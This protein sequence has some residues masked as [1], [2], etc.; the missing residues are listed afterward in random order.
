M[1]KYII[2]WLLITLSIFI[3]ATIVPGIEVESIFVAFV[4]AIVL[5]IINLLLKPILLIL[6]LPINILTLGL[7]TLFINAFLIILASKIVDGF[8]V[9][10]FLWAFVF[11]IILSLVHFVIHAVG[12]K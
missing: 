10:S 8:E 9:G 1:I 12:K 5:G 3:A 6:T 11:S 4:A 2:N 7:F